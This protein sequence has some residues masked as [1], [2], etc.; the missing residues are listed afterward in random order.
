MKR[1]WT[2][3]SAMT[4]TISTTDCAAEPPK[5]SPLKPS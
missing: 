4:I 3:V 2:A 1:N 5:S